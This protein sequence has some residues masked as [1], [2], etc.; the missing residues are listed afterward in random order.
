MPSVEAMS[1]SG[2]LLS[3]PE[4]GATRDT[5]AA[6]PPR[7]V[8]SDGLHALLVAARAQHRTSAGVITETLRKAIIQ[9]VIAGGAALRQDDLAATLAVSR[10]PIREALRQLE[11][12]GLIEFTPHKGAVVATLD[13]GDVEEIAEIRVALEGLALT[14]SFPHLSPAIL[15]AAETILD[16]ID[17]E[18]SLVARSALNRSF[19]A[20]LY[21]GVRRRRLERQIQT[22]YDGFDR[23]LRLEHSLL[24]RRETSQQEHRRILSA[25][26]RG[27]LAVALG[28]LRHHIADA[29]GGLAAYLRQQD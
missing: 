11:V 26:R 24:D 7:A 9:G 5:W 3:A 10:M 17:G 15:D 12:E 2:P 22:L 14:L 18:P 25:C 13:P 21:S 6:E 27:N 20:L 8:Q 16:T 19:H 1:K 29:G 28:E 23:Y 4:P